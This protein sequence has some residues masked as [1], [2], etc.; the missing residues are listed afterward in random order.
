MLI[1]Y[2]SLAGTTELDVE[3]SQTVEQ[4]KEMIQDKTGE[5]KEGL[6][7]IFQGMPLEDTRTIADYNIKEGATVGLAPL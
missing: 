3:P 5:P 2:R 6:L 4:L 7:I 1:F